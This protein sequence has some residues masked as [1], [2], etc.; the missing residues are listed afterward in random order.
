MLHPYPICSVVSHITSLCFGVIHVHDDMESI[1]LMRT[2][3][4]IADPFTD[5]IVGRYFSNFVVLQQ[6]K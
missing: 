5:L 1:I 3:I 2:D 6:N 4:G